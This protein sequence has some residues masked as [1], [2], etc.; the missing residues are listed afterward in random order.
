MTIGP[1]IRRARDKH[2]LTQSELAAKAGVSRATVARV[3]LGTSI[4]IATLEKIL[5][6]LNMEIDLRKAKHTPAC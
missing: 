6:A 3:E 5:D 1:Q 2:S 4:S